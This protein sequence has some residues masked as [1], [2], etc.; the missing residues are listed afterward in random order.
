MEGGRPRQTLTGG[1]PYIVHFNSRAAKLWSSTLMNG[2]D[3]YHRAWGDPALA[4]GRLLRYGQTWA[5]SEL[6][7]FEALC[8]EAQE[9]ALRQK[10]EQRQQQQKEEEERLKQQ[11]QSLQQ[12]APAAT[13]TGA[14]SLP[15]VATTS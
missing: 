11:A 3:A 10:E 14:A 4:D 7:T 13:T 2:T 15:G 5:T 12:Q 9:S 1:S 8:T 6:T